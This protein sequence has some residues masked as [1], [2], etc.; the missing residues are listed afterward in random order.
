MGLYLLREFLVEMDV[1]TRQS[2]VLAVVEPNERTIASGITNLTRSV[3][4][5]VGPTLA[6]YAMR[7][8][9]LSTPLFIGGGLKIV[10]DCWLYAGFRHL[11]PPEERRA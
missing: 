11:K 3:A 7:T 6:G 9:A 10:Y 1:P 2:Y 5:A 8:L 4:W